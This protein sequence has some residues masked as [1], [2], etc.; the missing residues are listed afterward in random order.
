MSAVRR[1]PLRLPLFIALAAT[2][3]VTVPVLRSASA[4]PTNLTATAAAYSVT[5]ITY[6]DGWQ[7]FPV[8]SSDSGI[9]V[10]Y[11]SAQS[12]DENAPPIIKA[13]VWKNGTTT[14]IPSLGGATANCQAWGVNNNGDVVG[15]SVT[16]DGAT[17]AFIYHSNNG[18]LEDLGNVL[19]DAY[20]IAYGINDAGQVVGQHGDYYFGNAFVWSSANGVTDLG[21]GYASS[22]NASGV[23]AG[24]VRTIEDDRFHMRPAIWQ[25]GNP[26]LLPYL[27]GDELNHYAADI[28]DSGTVVGASMGPDAVMHA[29]IWRNG[30]LT[31]LGTLQTGAYA[32]ATSIN[33]QGQ[34]VGGCGIGAFLWQ[35]GQMTN[36]T[37]SVPHTSDAFPAS[38]VSI[39]NSGQ[40][41]CQSF[42]MGSTWVGQVLTPG[43]TPPPPTDVKLASFTA[44]PGSITLRSQPVPVT[45]TLGLS[46]KTKAAIK[47]PLTI[48]LNGETVL[49][50]LV[51]IGKNKVSSSTTLQFDREWTP[52]TYTLTASYGGVDKTATLVVSPAAPV[53][54]KSLTFPSKVKRGKKVNASLSLTDVPAGVAEVTLSLLDS[55]QTQITLLG[56]PVQYVVKLDRKDSINAK[57]TIPTA[58]PA[59]TYY[60]S[61]S[62]GGVTKSVQFQA[63]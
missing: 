32:V 44:N 7:V 57:V 34:V 11:V 42:T 31:D 12:G 56:V 28:N 15:E 14:L 61:A 27:G 58:L 43:N 29:V 60:V 48:K 2:L 41:A 63:Q 19:G 45:F 22:I 55:T 25:N 3:S 23:I 47:V 8:A 46:A 52:G 36:L 17:H 33:N 49:G 37:Q 38:A 26:T 21:P 10:G 1:T 62:Y 51:N 35:N 39:N 53:T 54:L 30:A 5:K 59:G 50:F 24:Q 9:V 6:Q 13:F 18:Q 40:I 4:A 20:S 16:A